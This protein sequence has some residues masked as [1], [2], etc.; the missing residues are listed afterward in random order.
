MS[1]E[2]VKSCL[3]DVSVNL[4]RALY[5]AGQAREAEQECEALNAVGMLD[6]KGLQIYAVS[7]W[8][9]GKNNQALHVARNL[10]K[11][12]SNIEKSSTSAAIALICQLIYH[13]SGLDVA[14]PFIFK[15]PREYLHGSKMGLVISSL[16]AL[17]PSHRL[18]LLVPSNHNSS[19]AYDFVTQLHTMISLSKMIHSSSE[20]TL[21]IHSGTKHLR[22]ALHLYPDSNLIRN[23]LG[24]FL[25]CSGDWSASS[26]ATRCTTLTGGLPVHTGLLLPLKVHGGSGAACYASCV[27][28]PKFSFPTCKCQP[29]NV[30]SVTDHLQKWLHQEPW[31]NE[32]HYLL[33]VNIVQRT[34]EEKF[35]P[36]LFLIILDLRHMQPLHWMLHHF[37]DSFSA[38]LQLCRAYAA[39]EDLK[40]L[41]NE[42]M[43]C[44]NV[45][46]VHPIGWL[47]LKLL[48]SRYQLQTEYGVVDFNFQMCCKELS[49]SHIWE[50]LFGLVRALCLLSND[51]FPNAEQAL[52]QSSNNLDRVDSCLLLAHGAVCMELARRQMGSH[53]LSRAMQCLIKAQ[54]GSPSPLP[55]V[56]VLL[57]QAEGSLSAKAKWE[58]N[59]RLEWFSWPAEIRPAEVYFQMHI[60]ARQSSAA[61]KKQMYIESQESPEKWVLRAIHLNPSCLRYWKV[62]LRLT[63]GS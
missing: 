27:K 8:K 25:L 29:T 56:S 46:T 13:I 61:S 48:E 42:Y 17:D 7:L 47:S 58:R 21:D 20:K 57:A 63:S 50:A 26:I 39:Q 52:A 53:F 60:L 6:C 38:H 18:K 54:R 55:I 44:L 4:A 19:K 3:V 33:I 32:A 1:E 24:M 2:A 10:A 37:G 45:K 51:D 9:L 43:N 49:S 35:P 23:Q 15:L 12:I 22:K 36:H 31:N 62:L 16:D 5:Q 34:R 40:N 30:L 28:A 11:N 41:R 14:I 59:L